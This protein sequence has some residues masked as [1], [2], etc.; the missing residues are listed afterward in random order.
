[1]IRDGTIEKVKL[2]FSVIEANEYGGI[3][4]G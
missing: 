2:G 4:I 3:D 1:M